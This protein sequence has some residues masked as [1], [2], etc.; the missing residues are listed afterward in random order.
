MAYDGTLSIGSEGDENAL[1]AWQD[2]EPLQIKYFSFCTWNNVYGFWEYNCP[3]FVTNNDH[4]DELD[5]EAESILHIELN[6]SH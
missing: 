6:R 5:I 3:D 4:D 1:M 2:P